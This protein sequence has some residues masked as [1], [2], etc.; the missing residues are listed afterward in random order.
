MTRPRP[1]IAL[2]LAVTRAAGPP[3]LLRAV[4]PLAAIGL[5]SAVIFGGYGMSPRDLM[6]VMTAS[7][8]VRVSLWIAWLFVTAPAARALLAT[9]ETFVLRALPAPLSWF[10]IVHAAH[11]VLLQAPWMLLHAAAGGRV[12]PLASLAAGLGAAALSAF[13]VAY[14][15]TPREMLAAIAIAAAVLLGAPWIALL[16]TAALALAVGVATAFRRAP[17]RVAST[18]RV[19]IP[20]SAP[21]ALAITHAAVLARRDAVTLARGAT[22]ALLA[23]IITTLAARNNAAAD[24]EQE[25]IVLAASAIPLALAVAGIAGR[26]LVTERALGW[27]LSSSGTSAALRAGVAAGLTATWGAAMGA[28]AGVASSI[29]MSDTLVRGARITLLATALGASLAGMA[30]HLAR[31]AEAPAGIDGTPIVVGMTVASV[32]SAAL[33]AWAGTL[34]IVPITALGLALAAAT[35]HLLARR[36]RLTEQAT[37]VAWEDA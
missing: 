17:E 6:R 24:H 7:T 36:E 21:L 28:I 26:V 29:A 9:P 2:A 33:A 14:P 19:W 13:V 27:L 31:R 10:W 34:A 8:G 25:A 5:A 1:F 18:G 4:P 12:A 23:A 16:L 3:A 22:G 35:P 32:L 15:R 30:A 37:R 20:A 11:L